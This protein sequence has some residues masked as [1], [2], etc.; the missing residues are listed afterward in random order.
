[1]IK[2]AYLFYLIYNS[3]DQ[4]KVL[5]KAGA[6]LLHIDITETLFNISISLQ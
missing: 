1:M 3:D 6:D 2:L 5:E 4:L